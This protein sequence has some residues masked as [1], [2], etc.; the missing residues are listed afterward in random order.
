MGNTKPYNTLFLDRDGV[1]NVQRIGD[2]VKS[3]EEFIFIDGTFEALHILSS[4]F[5]HI[6]IVTNQRGVGR[7][8]MTLQQ[9][10]EIHH[11]MLDE[12]ASHNGRIDHIYFCTDTDDSNMNRKPNIG[13]ALQ[14]KQ[15]FPD[16]N[17]SSSVMVGDSSS[18]M[19]FANNANIP[20]ILIGNKYTKE[21]IARLDIQAHYPDLLT[22]ARHIDKD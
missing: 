2:Y 4:F 11:Y 18:D 12:I 22:F 19:Q 16:I 15:D 14:A 8:K 17:F 5:T 13:M 6:I 3:I 1:I 7:G 9:L 10:E 20:A 21:E